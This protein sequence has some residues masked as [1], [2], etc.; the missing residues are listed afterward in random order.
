MRIESKTWFA[1]SAESRT[2]YLRWFGKIFV[3]YG[4]YVQEISC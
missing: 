1:M 2:Q 3:V 4:D